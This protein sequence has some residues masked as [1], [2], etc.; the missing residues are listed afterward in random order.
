MVCG[1]EML[2]STE[3]KVPL[4]WYESFDEETNTTFL[5]TK[6]DMIEERREATRYYNSK[7]MERKFKI[8]ETVFRQVFQ[9]TKEPRAGALGYS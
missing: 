9:N 8:G 7:V 3:V 4:F 6:R 5:A 2:I 1:T